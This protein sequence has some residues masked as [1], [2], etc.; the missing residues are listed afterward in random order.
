MR[1]TAAIAMMIV[2]S[3]GCTRASLYRMASDRMLQPPP[4]YKVYCWT[5]GADLPS[6]EVCDAER[7]QARS[8]LRQC[9]VSAESNTRPPN[10]RAAELALQKCM[11]GRGWTLRLRNV[12]LAM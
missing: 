3:S 10:G 12:Q 7:E 6:Q 1:V 4:D 5:K 8:D 11:S 9:I 2:A